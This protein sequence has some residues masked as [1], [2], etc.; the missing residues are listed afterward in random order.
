MKAKRYF[1][2]CVCAFLLA[3]PAFS[4]CLP[5]IPDTAVCTGTE[6][7][8]A[9]N[10]IIGA[11]TTKYFYGAPAV[12]TSL[13]IQSG[14]KLIVCGE[15]QIND[16]GMT[17]GTLVITRTGRLTLNTS[18]GMSMVFTGDCAI[19]NTGYLRVLCNVVLD[20][21]DAWTNPT[22][23]NIVWIG[24]T[25]MIDMPHTYFV[26]QKGNCF[27]VNKGTANFSGIINSSQ[28]A[29]NSV[30]LGDRSR[31]YVSL[32]ENRILNTYQAPEGPACVFVRSWGFSYANLTAW[33]SVMLC[34]ASTYCNGGCGAGTQNWGSASLMNS[35]SSCMGLY[36]LPITPSP[37][38]S[39]LPDLPVNPEV[40]PNPFKEEVTVL[41][42]KTEF[43][44]EVKL[45]S[46]NGSIVYHLPVNKMQTRLRI[47]PG[48]IAPGIYFVQV[49]T[50]TRTYVLRTVKG[51]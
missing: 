15:L 41:L 18:G 27:F 38:I 34:R 51:V 45:V 17:G 3:L 9:N 50:T 30:C 42:P 11:G 20:G 5:A 23:P 37:H 10:E 25:G 29:A 22:L 16:F 12:F 39:L 31:M 35:C 40:L 47:R 14:G 6:P 7:L 4:Q 44:H 21:P 24:Q 28:S 33:P 13:R 36:L 26:L 43:I 48:T 49:T 46:T 1:I 2:T 8:V 32:L 19:Y